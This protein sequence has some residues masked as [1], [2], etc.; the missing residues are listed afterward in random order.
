[1]ILSSGSVEKGGALSWDHIVFYASGRLNHHPIKSLLGE[2]SLFMPGEGGGGWGN[3]LARKVGG[4]E[5]M[6]KKN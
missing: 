3:G 5:K 1:M 2:G 4:H 6:K